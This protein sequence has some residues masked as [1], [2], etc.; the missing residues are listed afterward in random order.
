[1][2]MRKKPNLLPRMERTSA[3]LAREPETLRGAWRTLLPGCAGVQLELGCGKG[4][5]TAET[6]ASMPDT[7]LAAVEKVPDAMV[8]AMERAVEKGLHNI[9]FIDRDVAL[10]PELF[11][12]GEVERIYLNFCDPGPRAGTPSTA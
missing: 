10:L 8:M 7:L 5:F 11:A 12:P 9:K 2:R 6:A 1:M 3:V 4:R